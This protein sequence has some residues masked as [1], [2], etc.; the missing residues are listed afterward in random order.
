MI[1]AP[2]DRA[3]APARASLK[4]CTIIA[5]IG[6]L[7]ALVLAPLALTRAGTWLVVEDPLEHATAVVVFGGQV[8]FRAME[9]AA[10][11][12]EGWAR[13]VWLTQGG[14][15]PEDLALARLRIDR[16]PE[17]EYSRQVLERLGVPEN[18]ICLIDGRT[19]NTAEEV[20]VVVRE[21]RAH[22][23]GRVILVTSKFHAR[24]VKVLWRRLVGDRPDAIVRYTP[25]DPFQPDAWW[26]NTEDAM[27]VS[28]E[29][30]GLINAWA[31]FPI[32]SERW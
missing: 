25:D 14:L 2:E 27:S 31:G 17:H 13:E 28:R 20:R 19:Q 8:P 12:R 7:A 11:Y 32:K 21:L 3:I 18:A 4:R 10:I 24:R 16:T 9:A 26:R 15:H 29:W 1:A 6:V 5:I 22:G 30:F 23:G